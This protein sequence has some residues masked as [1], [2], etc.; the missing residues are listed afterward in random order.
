MVDFDVVCKLRTKQQQFHTHDTDTMITFIRGFCSDRMNPKP[1]TLRA[2][3]YMRKKH[4][5]QTRVSGEPYI[6]HP[7]SMAC[8]AIGLGLSNDSLL[9]VTLLHDVCEDTN[10]NINDLPFSTAVRQGVKYM[11]IQKLPGDADK[12]ETKRR[13]FWSLLE[14]ANALLCKALDRYSNLNSMV[15]VLSMDRVERNLRETHD[16]LLPVLK[17]A[18]EV[19]PEYANEI[20]TLRTSIRDMNDVI[21]MLCGIDIWD[22]QMVVAKCSPLNF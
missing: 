5:G 16:L 21:A 12:A 1:E 15:G 18:K 20:H 11:T 3:G 9:A 22:A 6:V 17:E 10:T 19:Y 8:H 2:L 14:D 4:E 7:L 13:Y